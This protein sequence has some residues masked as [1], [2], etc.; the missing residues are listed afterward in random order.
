[1][2]SAED[3]RVEYDGNGFEFELNTSEIWAAD[4]LRVQTDS[5]F[6]WIWTE[7]KWNVC[8]IPAQLNR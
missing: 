6:L 7:N 8:G 1:M 5:S 3:R 4:Y 2:H